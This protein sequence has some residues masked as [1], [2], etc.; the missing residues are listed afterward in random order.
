MGPSGQPARSAHQGEAAAI[1]DTGESGQPARRSGQEV[2]R[3]LHLHLPQGRHPAA[4]AHGG[5]RPR[6]PQGPQGAAT[7]EED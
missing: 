2:H 3:G 4:A 1:L 6:D 5:K 7:R